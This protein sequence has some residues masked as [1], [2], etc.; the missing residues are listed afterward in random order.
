MNLD[1][2]LIEPTLQQVLFV[3]CIIE[4][5]IEY[6]SIPCAFP[7]IEHFGLLVH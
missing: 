3:G 5:A 1:L 2:A 6:T 7:M 4:G